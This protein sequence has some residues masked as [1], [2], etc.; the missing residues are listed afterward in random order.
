MLE[1]KAELTLVQNTVHPKEI[2]AARAELE[3]LRRQLAFHQGQPA[4]TRLMMP[5]SGQLVST[6]LAQQVG[7]YLHVGEL[8]AVAEDKRSVGVEISVPEA[9]I[10]EVAIGA[11]TRM[12]VWTYPGRFFEGQVTEIDPVVTDAT[13]GKVWSA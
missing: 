7:S 5:F 3:G 10:G 12:Q 2:E 8:F 1:Q 9:D 11:P 13:F 6:N 4:R